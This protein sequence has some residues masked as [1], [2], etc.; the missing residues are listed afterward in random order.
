PRLPPLQDYTVSAE[1]SSSLSFHPFIPVRPSITPGSMPP[2]LN[3][4]SDAGNQ[5]RSGHCQSSHP[6]PRSQIPVSD[7]PSL[8]ASSAILIWSFLIIREKQILSMPLQI[9]MAQKCFKQLRP[10]G[11]NS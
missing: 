3:F 6:T 11:K 2:I 4:V 7:S 5:A 8:F 10:E 9:S 1:S